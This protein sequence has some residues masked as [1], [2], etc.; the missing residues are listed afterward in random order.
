MTAAAGVGRRGPARRRWLLVAAAAFGALLAWRV[1]SH[2]SRADDERHIAALRARIGERLMTRAQRPER[3]P[4]DRSEWDEGPNLALSARTCVELVRGGAASEIA[5]GLVERA[6]QA[7]ELAFTYE[8]AAL[9]D[10][11]GR[12]LEATV[13]GWGTSKP[14]SL[15]TFW[16]ARAIDAYSTGT[17]LGGLSELAQLLLERGDERGGR[18]YA[19]LVPIAEYW[20]A[21]RQFAAPGGP[22]FDK[23]AVADPE[24][25]RHVVHNTDALMGHA[26]LSLAGAATLAGDVEPARRYRACAASVARQLEH[27]LIDRIAQHSS[28]R[29][30]DWTYE[31]VQDGVLF[32]PHRGEDTNHASYVID[33]LDAVVTQRLA[34]D[35]VT[36]TPELIERLGASFEDAIVR[37]PDGSAATQLYVRASEPTTDAREKQRAREFSFDAN[38]EYPRATVSL[39]RE[40]S[41]EKRTLDLGLSIR[42]SWGWTKALRHRPDLLV[43]LGGYLAEMGERELSRNLALAQAVFW[44]ESGERRGDRATRPQLR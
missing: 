44:R 6:Y 36:L 33:F 37:R 24:I 38:A 34:L 5:D 13:R 8:A 14:L 39:W 1:L 20:L 23:I 28:I 12:E 35:A 16:V 41:G 11:G 17:A 10:Q 19:R 15:G 43:I 29:V 25:R 32:T 2:P 18:L 27:N 30:A 31:L 21:A 9:R 40:L 26:L 3:P 4:T 22:A 42:T 7:A